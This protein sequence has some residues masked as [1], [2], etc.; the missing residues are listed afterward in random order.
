MRIV[1][2]NMNRRIGSPQV[3]ERLE[4]ALERWQPE[5]FLVQEPYPASGVPQPRVGRYGYVAATPLLA[6]L[7]PESHPAPVV[8]VLSERWHRI[9]WDAIEIHHVYLDASSSKRRR[10][11]LDDL[12]RWGVRDAIVI[13]DFNLA[14]SPQDG[15]FGDEV[16]RFTSAGE[17]RAFQQLLAS[18]SLVD[19]GADFT[20][21][22]YTFEREQRGKML[23]FRCDLA[24]IPAQLATDCALEFDHSVRGPAGFTDHSAVVVHLKLDR[25][26][27]RTQITG[28]DLPR[29]AAKPHRRE[30]HD[31]ACPQATSSYKTAIAR[32][33]P[34]A[35]AARLDADGILTR[36]NI[37]SVLDFGCGYG[38][39][40]E[41][42]RSLGLEAE[43]FDVET[44][45]GFPRPNG[46]SFDL[47]TVVYVVN[48]LPTVEARLEAVR[49]A[50]TFVKPGGCLLIAARSEAAVRRE[51]R[52]GQWRSWGD[53]W[54]SSEAKGTF[55]TGIR[56]EFL[57]WLLGKMGMELVD[58]QLSLGPEVTWLL[59]RRTR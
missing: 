9:R 4:R 57:G 32:A 6:V 14:P 52:K 49:E 27:G 36:F 30:Q 37:G 46:R 7:S 1:S 40:V 5:L 28:E 42:Y 56:P 38:R 35:I 34:S 53:G 24:L 10:E 12:R 26:A 17:R 45:F 11:L 13:G 2:L 58:A 44:R 47:V 43:G 23:R 50:A 29:E 3:R 39:D 59:G 25:L 54:V 20:G 18:C 21:R 33:G 16:S 31:Q 41:F 8:E 15:L 22:E 19:A 51:A 48:V 55:Q